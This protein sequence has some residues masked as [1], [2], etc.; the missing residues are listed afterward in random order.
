MVSVCPVSR[1][2][3]RVM[4]AKGFS[5]PGTGFSATAIPNQV[6]KGDKVYIQGSSVDLGGYYKT[7]EANNYSQVLI[8]SGSH[9]KVRIIL[10]HHPLEWH[11]PHARSY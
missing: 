3:T 9:S 11:R 10:V 4:T 8:K 1:R 7:L 6:A 2:G 5:L